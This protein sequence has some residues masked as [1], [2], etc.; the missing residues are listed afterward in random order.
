MNFRGKELADAYQAKRDL[1]EK[2]KVMFFHVL[3]IYLILLYVSVLDKM[4]SVSMCL[5]LFFVS[6]STPKCC[7]CCCASSSFF[8]VVYLEAVLLLDRVDVFA[9][10][11]KSF[12][13][14]GSTGTWKPSLLQ[15][16]YRSVARFTREPAADRLPASG[17][18][19]CA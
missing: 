4:L 6:I 13:C 18:L 3:S 17:L 7:L 15:R 9:T 14:G 12:D 1:E 19:S 8:V 2:D 16:K 5:I 10:C 11:P